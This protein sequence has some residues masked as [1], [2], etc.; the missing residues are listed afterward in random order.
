MR[1]ADDADAMI[2]AAAARDY[3]A[4]LDVFEQG[5]QARVRSEIPDAIEHRIDDSAILGWISA[6]ENLAVLDAAWLVLGEKSAT[7][8]ITAFIANFSK[9]RFLRT[10]LE[11]SGLTPR[12]I[13]R[14]IPTAWGH[15][16]RN[17]CRVEIAVLENGAATLRLTGLA[18]V[19]ASSDTYLA[20]FRGLLLGIYHLTG[21]TGEVSQNARYRG[22]GEVEYSLRWLSKG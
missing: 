12:G 20:C 7:Q 15:V 2:R 6:E 21:V 9:S 17:V 4:F 14:L 19:V 13:I 1:A 22:T 3:L 18:P 16:Y 8:S 11:T 5:L 10:L